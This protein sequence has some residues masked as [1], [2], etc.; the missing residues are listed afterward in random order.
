MAGKSPIEECTT[1]IRTSLEGRYKEGFE[2][3]RE[4]DG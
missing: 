2:G 3:F 1:T 4:S